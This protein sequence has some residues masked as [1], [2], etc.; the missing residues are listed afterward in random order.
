M[1]E[2]EKLIK[3]L[4]SPKA[5]ARYDAC[6]SLRVAPSL[7]DAAVAALER[8]SNDSDP[9]VRDAAHRALNLHKT[10]PDYVK[11]SCPSCGEKLEITSDIGHLTCA[12]CGFTGT[13]RELAVRSTLESEIEE[14]QKKRSR[15]LYKMNM[16][17]LVA[18]SLGVIACIL[19]LLLV[20][21]ESQSYEVPFYVGAVLCGI[22][23][24]LG[25]RR[26]APLVRAVDQDIER[27]QA[28]L[29]DL[30]E[31]LFRER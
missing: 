4:E 7:N 16:Y 30:K 12:A 29:E 2:V 1:D 3:A 27:K 24:Y 11:P 10:A 22:L 25:G 14:L 31:L 20:Y 9:E 21:A 23:A 8:A 5:S 6:E 17:Y 19:S 18:I 26:N 28:E 13:P 15:S